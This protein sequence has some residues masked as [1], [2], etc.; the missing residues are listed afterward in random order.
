MFVLFLDLVKAYDRVVRELVLGWPKNMKCAGV[1]YLRTLGVGETATQWI[2]DFVDRTGGLLKIWGVDPKV[3]RLIS[4]MHEGSWFRYGDLDTIIKTALGGRQG[5][6]FGSLIFNSGYSI[7]LSMLHT[8][9]E[10]VGVTLNIHESPNAFWSQVD[11]NQVEPHSAVDATFVDDECLVI[12]APTPHQLD[13]AID[14]LLSAVVRIF[15]GL[16]LDIN[17]KP[18]KSEC[19]LRYRGKRA[20]SK[21]DQRRIDG[22]LWVQVKDINNCYLSVVQCYKH[23][24]GMITIEGND[25]PD[26]NHKY[27]SAMNAYVPLAVK[28]F[29]DPSITDFLKLHFVQS[30]ILSRLFFNAHIVV[31]SARYVEILNRAYMRVLRRICDKVN[32]DGT[33]GSDLQVR[34]QACQPS[35]DCLLQR[36]RLKYLRRLVVKAPSTLLALLHSRHSESNAQLAWTKLVVAD[37]GVLRLHV[38]LCSYLP[39]PSTNAEDWCTFIT[40]DEARWELAIATLFFVESICDSDITEAS[41]ETILTFVCQQCIGSANRC[42]FATAKALQQ[43]ARVKHAARIDIRRFVDSDAVCPACKTNFRQRFRC[44]AHLSDSRRKNCYLQILQMS[45]SPLPNERV[46]E[47]DALDRFEKLE[48]RK[49]GHT[50]ILATGS[51]R[52]SNGKRIGHVQK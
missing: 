6:K 8:E 1:E 38:P 33:A 51:A 9:L 43:H 4:S 17:W 26:A 25:V 48:A 44:I 45:L 35:V 12:M 13:I 37:M 50:H 28:V 27:G 3:R 22:K 16:S 30:L 20:S 7:A 21:Y 31:P 36:L 14:M 32:Y 24:G 5:C 52:R 15:K 23:L 19:M 47:L 49:K 34:S 11:P 40:E 41:D 18:G 2:A 46:Q 29:G 39:D 10:S 42:R